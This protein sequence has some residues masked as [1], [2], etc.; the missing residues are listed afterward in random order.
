M[1][2]NER[3]NRPAV[4]LGN[5]QEVVARPG[6]PAGVTLPQMYADWWSADKKKGGVMSRKGKRGDGAAIR[7]PRKWHVERSS[8]LADE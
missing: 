7:A 1:C 3:Q 2:G 6:R 8:T 5:Q 4:D